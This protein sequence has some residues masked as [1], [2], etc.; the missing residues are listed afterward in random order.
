MPDL[1]NVLAQLLF[2]RRRSYRALFLTEGGSYTRNARQVLADLRRFCR[3][4]DT[5]FAASQAETLR[6]VGRLEVLNRIL[7]H[8]EASEEDI[9]RMVETI[10][11]QEHDG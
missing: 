3:A 6:N 2:R 9:Y 7:S 8:C 10:E 5:P 4:T 1:S 11:G